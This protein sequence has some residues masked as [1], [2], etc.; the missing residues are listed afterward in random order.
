MLPATG[1]SVVPARC[2]RWSFRIPPWLRCPCHLW[3]RDEENLVIWGG[4][5]EAHIDR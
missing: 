1:P 3:F 2:P 5:H 4:T